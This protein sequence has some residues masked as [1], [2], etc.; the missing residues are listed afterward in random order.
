MVVLVTMVVVVE[1]AAAA[2]SVQL[3]GNTLAST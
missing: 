3:D 2:A 1:C